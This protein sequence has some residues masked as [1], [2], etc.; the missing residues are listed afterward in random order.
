M[1]AIEASSTPADAREHEGRFPVGIVLLGI[2][3]LLL[4]YWRVWGIQP[5]ADDYNPPLAEVFRGMERGPLTFFTE[6]SAYPFYRPLT[7]LTT[8][9][10][11]SISLP[12]IVTIVH[13][14]HFFWVAAA[15]VVLALWARTLA[16]RPWMTT[17]AV[18][19]FVA[20]PALSGPL[21]SI[22]GFQRIASAV[23][24]W[25]GAWF[26]ARTPLGSWRDDLLATAC[27]A[28]GLGFAEYALG[29]LPLAGLC[30]LWRVRDGR[31]WLAVVRLLALLVAV[32]LAW[33]V[34]RNLVIGERA[35]ELV[36][37]SLA[38]LLMNAARLISVSLLWI[39]SVWAVL[40]PQPAARI[41]AIGAIGLA[42]AW[43]G[44]G[45]WLA[46]RD[47]GRQA[48]TRPALLLLMLAAVTFP[49]IILEH[50][51]ELYAVP[52]LFPVALLAALA[53][54]GYARTGPALRRA[55]LALGGLAIG[56]GLGASLEKVE[57]IAQAGHR[58][59][60]QIHQ[61][62]SYVPDEADSWR[63]ALVFLTPQ[64]GPRYSVFA[65]GDDWVIQPGHGTATLKWFRPGQ[66]LS[67][68]HLIRDDVCGIDPAAFDLVLLWDAGARRFHPMPRG[69]VVGGCEGPA[70]G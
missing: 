3:V 34:V 59:S 11:G 47:G 57:G 62:L 60:D 27:L 69:G 67:V 30:A 53:A 58:A 24:V 63:I 13:A 29:L 33:Y 15:L 20:H 9:A 65:Q 21:G 18:L 49:M 66:H 61:I 68:E 23:W 42:V 25:L 16:F 50:V 7:F 1:T 48:D 14:V 28:V 51:S 43:G 22:D 5:S 52:F 26:V 44:I 12:H 38:H 70:G 54:A 39:S 45:L 4:A 31:P 6:P 17:V 40:G 37:L 10:A 36:G 55:G 2:L 46:R 41:V 35:S 32:T 56:V 19:V 8:W 64:M